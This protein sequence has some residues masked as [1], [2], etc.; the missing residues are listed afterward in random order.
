M[1]KLVLPVLAA[2]LV[3]P[4]LA[5]APG[6][7]LAFGAPVLVR[8]GSGE[9]GLGIGPD[10]ALYVNTLGNGFPLL[11]TSFSDP[12]AKSTDGG[13]T[14]LALPVGP[15]VPFGG[16]DDHLIVAPDN[17]VYLAA[18]WIVPLNSGCMTVSQGL[19]GGLAWVTQPDA[20]EP[21]FL[22]GGA[23]RPWLAYSSAGGPLGTLYLFYHDP[24]CT[25][26]QVVMKST[27]RGLTWG[28]AGVPTTLGNFP[29]NIVVDDAAGRV[30]TATAGWMGGSV[31]VSR[32]ADQGATWQE[33][34]VSNL[35]QGDNGLNHVFLAKDAAGTLYVAWADNPA[36]AWNIY[37]SRSTDQGATWSPRQQVSDTSG[38]HIFPALGAG[39]AGRVVVAW[40]EN[41]SSANPNSASSGLWHPRA[42]GSWDGG[43]TWTTADV[44][45]NPNHAGVL[46]TRGALCGSQGLNRRMLDF[47]TL[48]VD[49]AD[50]A[51]VVWADDRSGSVNLP[52]PEIY[53]AR[54]L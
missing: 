28:L 31:R 19:A 33:A 45:T 36:G 30:Y 24:C 52:N 5:V 26:R 13:Q 48:Q 6:P 14:W 34:T 39:S 12:I 15:N 43:A 40:Y 20:C 53:F 16:N 46:C 42:A 23:D 18:Q 21:S 10:G 7:A 22:D 8:V 37:L 9:P 11:G 25:G 47:F 3:V 41:P 4:V 29:G 50:R 44:T 51:N 35:N 32:S 49:G 54:S 27:T 1:R 2:L 17:T 38:T